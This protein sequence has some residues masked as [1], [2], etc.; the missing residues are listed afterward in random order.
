MEYK[1]GLYPAWSSR[2]SMGCED[3]PNN[4][5]AT[6]HISKSVAAPKPYFFSLVDLT[7]YNENN[8]TAYPSDDA[9]N[10]SSYFTLHGKSKPT[11]SSGAIAGIAV[12]GFFGLALVVFVVYLLMTKQKR[13]DKNETADLTWFP[14]PHRDMSEKRSHNTHDV[15][16]PRTPPKTV[17]SSEATSP[18]SDLTSSRRVSPRD[19]K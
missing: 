6:C 4:G 8:A 19:M 5:S 17:S 18:T 16:A 13:K 2:I 14:F 10:D 1:G 12:G 3:L 11:L 15:E 7:K 9:L